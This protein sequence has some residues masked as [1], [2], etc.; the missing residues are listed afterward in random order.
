M[1]MPI[2]NFSWADN[3]HKELLLNFFKMRETQIKKNITLTPWHDFFEKQNIGSFLRVD[4]E[5]PKE[6]KKLL[7]V[8]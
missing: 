4:L 7:P 3:D 8:F 2:G 5:Y 6:V 1:P